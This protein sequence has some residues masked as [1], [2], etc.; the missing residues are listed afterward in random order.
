MKNEA[1][2][3]RAGSSGNL[4]IFAVGIQESIEPIAIV[5]CR[6]GRKRYQRRLAYGI[7]RL[8]DLVRIVDGLHQQLVVLDFD[9]YSPLK[10]LELLE[11]GNALLQQ[12]RR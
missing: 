2:T 12:I 8:P 3:V 7:S 11:Q 10:T 9:T 6:A 1:W 4:D 5:P